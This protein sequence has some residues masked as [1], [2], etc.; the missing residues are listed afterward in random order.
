V[1]TPLQLTRVNLQRFKAAYNLADVPL[2]PFNVLIG[3]N[4]A[5]KSTLLEALQWIDT[6]VRH[7]TNAACDRYNG[8]RDLINHRD[9]AGTPG[10]VIRTYLESAS[11]SYANYSCLIHDRENQATVAVETLRID[12]PGQPDEHWV[13]DTMQT[14]IRVST[15][16]R[17]NVDDRLA[18]SRIDEFLPEAILG[19]AGS[20]I[21][22]FWA[23]AVFLRLEPTDLARGG[24][25]K[26]GSADP[27][28]NE[29]GSSL[30]ALLE[31]LDDD[32]RADL[33]EMLQS[34]L[35]DFRGVEVMRASDN[36]SGN[37][38]L[39]EEIF[40]HDHNGVKESRIPSWMLSEGTRRMTAIFALLARRPGPSLL[41]IEEIENGLDP[42]AV[43]K[44]LKYLEAASRRGVQV[45]LTTHSPWLLDDV[46][47][48]SI[49]LV[50]R[51]QG[52]T[53]YTRLQD[54]PAS[55]QSDPRVL[56]GGRYLDLLER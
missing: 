9:P 14:G 55:Q 38:A 12:K 27:L 15:S 41:C 7:T 37:Y 18:L 39:T 19:I 28:L 49:Q 35:P 42:I 23:N 3:R 13:I 6:A 33:V 48:E 20:D 4:G 17:I 8:I 43:R 40:H 29:V 31:S 50:R 52:D 30:T 36:R 21:A 22:T 53:T 25:L 47:L 1:T 2:L 10:F 46:P 5:G 54:D 45:I 11:G 56:P 16:A 24:P 34:V 44:V 51:V 32:A 26:R